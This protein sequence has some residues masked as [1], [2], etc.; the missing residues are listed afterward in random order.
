[1]A[2]RI[3]EERVDW[4]RYRRWNAAIADVVYSPERAGRP[5]Y[6]DLEDDVLADIAR[7]AEPEAADATEA[8]IQTVTATLD[9]RSGYAGILRDHLGKLDAWYSGRMMDPPPCLALLAMLSIVAESMRQTREMR[10]HNFYGRLGELLSLSSK[11]LSWFEQAYRHR[12]HREAA[13]E[14]LWGA[15]NDWL[16]MLDG[17]RG[18]PTAFPIGHDHV[19]LPLSQALVRDADRQKFVDLFVTQGLCGGM[20]I[21]VSDMEVHIDEW[22][23]RNPCPASNTLEHLWKGQPSTRPAIAEV[24][25]LTLESW[26]GVGT[27]GAAPISAARTIDTVKAKAALL[28]FP[29]PRLDVSLVIPGHGADLEQVQI[30]D[31]DGLVLGTVEVVPCAS[32]WLGLANTAALDVG[33]FL[34][35]DVRLRREGNTQ[36]LVRRPRR[37]VPLRFDTMLN[38]YIECERIQ[39]GEEALVLATAELSDRVD[40]FLQL[41]ARPGYRRSNLLQG[42]PEG[43]VLFDHVQVLRSPP[44]ALKNQRL[45]LNL[46][47]PTSRSQV[48]LQG[49]LRLPGYLRKWHSSRPPELRITMEDGG[50]IQASVVCK[51]P[52]VNPPPPDLTRDQAGTVL[53]WDLREATLPDGDYTITAKADGRVVASELLRLRSADN[54]APSVDPDQ[55]PIAHDPSEVGFELFASRSSSASSFTVAPSTS[56]ELVAAPAPALLPDWWQERRGERERPPVAVVRFPTG[57]APCITSGAHH[58]DIATAQGRTSVDG[59]CRHCGLVKR[60]PTKPRR[61]KDVASRLADPP[62]LSLSEVPPVRAEDTIDWSVA[63]DAVCHV[64]GGPM[65]ALRRITDQMDAT[66]LFG[67]AFARRLEVLGHIEV[68]RH[69]KTLQPI[70]WQVNAPTLVG[71]P[72]GDVVLTGFRSERLLVA[73]EDAAWQAGHKVEAQD[74]P[75]AP[76]VVR[77][78][79]LESTHAAAL[80]EGVSAALSCRVRHIPDAANKLA[81]RLTLL[82]VSAS[83]LPPSVVTAGVSCEVWDPRTA[84]FQRTTDASGSGAFRLTANGRVYIFR[85]RGSDGEEAR[86]GNARI[87]KYLAAAECQQSLVG[88]DQEQ[89]ILYVPLGADLPGLYGRA[90]V[91]ASGRPPLDNP[92]EGILEY[93]RVPPALASHLNHLLM[94]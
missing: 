41:V 64:G 38:A 71:L 17:Q 46:L 28:T 35:G 37:L 43:W 93:H 25:M 6:L 18:T 10:A 9:F 73:L 26:D 67:D 55:P 63:F 22:M 91:L 61:R 5:V 30:C 42:L 51:R 47:Q 87:V 4:D 13:S 84:H 75:D 8:L 16:E 56:G 36:V 33:S 11:Q 62:Q 45:E 72:S 40:D 89:E 70:A 60:Y 31:S 81:S 44:E 59:I 79:G 21:P 65:S 94:S 50:E 3:I 57:N 2:V 52:M 34:V 69:P 24:A 23:A 49:G 48:V 82:R 80:A 15:L 88:Y 86:V 19:G 7:R 85:P 39:L 29:R 74:R 14:E 78:R 68:E 32:G 53:I 76:D 92:G 12:R 20:T 77:V 58:M 83:A 90:A 66:D 27:D 54:P 1:M